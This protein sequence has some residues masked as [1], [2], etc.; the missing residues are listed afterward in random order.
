MPFSSPTIERYVA[1]ISYSSTDRD[2][3][4]W[5][6]RALER[7]VVPKEYRHLLPSPGSKRLVPIFRDVDEFASSPDLGGALKIALNKSDAL[8]VLCSSNSASSKWVA[9]E[10]RIFSEQRGAKPIIAAVIEDAFHHREELDFLSN[11][12]PL[13]ADL[14][15]RSRREL[16]RIVAYTLGSEFE[17]FR[18]R[19]TIDLIRRRIVHFSTIMLALVL[20]AYFVIAASDSIRE[21]AKGVRASASILNA[22][23][24]SVFSVGDRTFRLDRNAM[25]DAAISAADE[26]RLT[27]T[28]MFDACAHWQ[29]RNFTLSAGDEWRFE[30]NWTLRKTPDTISRR[31]PSVPE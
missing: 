7:Y 3:A 11:W 16:T 18:K 1:F 29:E 19:R 23:C 6:H 31:L 10:V 24:D 8:I 14:R 21:N 22:A 26:I 28:R 5:L 4:K 9:E 30:P 20:V 17:S 12:N 25:G 27:A 2:V 13:I 15:E